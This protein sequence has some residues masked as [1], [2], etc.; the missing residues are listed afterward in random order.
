ME[1]LTEQ[2]VESAQ[3][4]ES[5]WNTTD[6]ER[7][8]EPVLPDEISSGLCLLDCGQA[9]NRGKCVS[10]KETFRSDPSLV[11]DCESE[12][13]FAEMTRFPVKN[14]FSLFYLVDAIQSFISITNSTSSL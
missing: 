8:G 5:A 7:D 4:E 6:E 14:R 10:G 12:A 2:C 1:D 9:D 11:Y 3:R 13:E